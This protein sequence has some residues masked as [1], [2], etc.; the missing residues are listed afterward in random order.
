MISAVKTPNLKLLL[1]ACIPGVFPG[2]LM[3]ALQWDTQERVLD[4]R[5]DDTELGTSFR[6][7]NTGED[8][9]VIL[10]VRHSCGCTTTGLDKE[11]FDP[12][13]SGEI[14][15]HMSLDGLMGEQAKSIMVY[16]SDNP[17]NPEVLWIYTDVPVR[18]QLNPAILAWSF[19]SNPFARTATLTFHP[20]LTFDPEQVE[21]VV[22]DREKMGLEFTTAIR[23]GKA[24]NTLQI[25]VLPVHLKRMGHAYL[26]VFWNH[27]GRQEKI[28]ELYLVVN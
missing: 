16:T 14:K 24:P 11:V 17:E 15:V 12:G 7:T 21:V 25:E 9:V 18:H 1:A 2:M 22:E 3:A 28:G 23:E 19:R 26:V 5:L 10:K 6:F 20:D 4:T 8:T 27:D 13:E